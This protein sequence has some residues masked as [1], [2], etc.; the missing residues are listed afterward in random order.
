MKI[1]ATSNFPAVTT[2]AVCYQT[3]AALSTLNLPISLKERLLK[4]Q[5][6]N[7][8]ILTDFFASDRR[9]VLVSIYTKLNGDERTEYLRIRGGDLSSALA[10]HKENS[11]SVFSPDD[12][13]AIFPIL[14]GLR[15]ASYRFNKL[16][17]KPEEKA[18]LVQDIYCSASIERLQELENVW[19]AVNFARDLVNEPNINQGA[20][21]LSESIQQ[22]GKTYGFNV[23]VLSHARIE[24]LKMGGLL[25]V[26]KGSVDPPTF[27]IMEWKPE[28]AINTKP[29]VLVGKGVVYDTGGLSLKPTANSMDLMKCDMAGAAAVAGAFC[30]IAANK[31]PVH[32][33]GLIP[34]TD[35]RPGGDAYAPGDVITMMD[36]TTVEVLNT[37]AEGRLILADALAY[38]KRYQPELVIDLATLTGAAARAIGKNAA[39]AMGAKSEQY[40][41][42]LLAHGFTSG[43]RLVEFPMWEE[44]KEEMK[45]NI[46]DL[47]NIGSG[48]AGMITAAKFLEHF[49]DYPYIHI[50]IAGP[51]FLTSAWRYHPIGATGAGVRV[52]YSFFKE[53]AGL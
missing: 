45:S 6:A 3:V 15:L 5:E 44:Y 42:K 28:N 29:F 33:V 37:D 17:S 20:L 23:E 46:A 30:A 48:D 2:E 40:M 53:Q 27:T 8:P 9:I 35:N 32:V 31:L 39:I 50:D 18:Y 4:A 49:T 7:T 11:A 51:A 41:P 12:P 21:E 43:D 19:A 14:E 52:L 26:N 16:F 47:K 38:A 34:A 36:G 13:E 25:A 24:T 10:T 22:A 1:H